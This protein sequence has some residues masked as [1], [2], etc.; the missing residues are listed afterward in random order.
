MDDP[1]IR[2]YGHRGGC[3]GRFPENSIPAFLSGIEGGADAIELDV[4]LSRD[5]H[6]VVIHDPV[7]DRVANGAGRVNDLGAAELRRYDL[8]DPKGTLHRGV[9]IPALEEVLVSCPDVQVNIDLKSDEVAL[10]RGVADVITR[11]EACHRVTVASFLPVALAHFRNIL[12][13]VETSLDPVEVRGLVRGRVMR[14]VPRFRGARV[15]VPP[16]R[17]VIPLSSRGF[18]RFCHVHR[19]AIDVWTINTPREV[20]RL[21]RHGVDGI[22]SDDARMVRVVLE[23]MGMR[24]RK[25]VTSD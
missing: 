5:G 18:V 25:G 9:H 7:I 12:P 19:M 11:Y 22:I 10:A 13:H 24:K 2:I 1:A 8:Y 17:G 16:R 6:V 21:A 3:G 20:R 15:Q 23:R 4:R 14:E